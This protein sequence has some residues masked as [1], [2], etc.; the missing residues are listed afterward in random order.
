MNNVE[1]V[2]NRLSDLNALIGEAQRDL[3]QGKVTNLSHL[4]KEVSQVCEQAL[5][6]PAEDAKKTQAPMA[7]MIGN[8][9]TLALSLQN[10][11]TEM[12]EKLK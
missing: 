1:K 3:G 12:K 10:F 4:D 7:D 11:Q 6:L 8:L 2:L 5:A 9:E